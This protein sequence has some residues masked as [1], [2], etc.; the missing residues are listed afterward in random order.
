MRKMVIKKGP[1][2]YKL[3][4]RGEFDDFYLIKSGIFR[5]DTINGIDY[6]VPVE[7][8]TSKW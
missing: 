2:R 6:P 7:Q 3:K 5:I 8:D 4:D 1:K